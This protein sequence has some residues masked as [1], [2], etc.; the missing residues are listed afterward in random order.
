MK[1]KEVVSLLN[2]KKLQTNKIIGY[3][4]SNMTNEHSE[5][6]IWEENDRLFTIKDGIKQNVINDELK[7]LGKVP[8][9]CPQCGNIM[10][11]T[12]D[13][14]FYYQFNK[15]SDCVITEDTEQIK[16]GTFEAKQKEIIKQNKLAWFNDLKQG[17]Y[18]YI[19]ELDSTD[20]HF[21][22]EMGTL[23]NWKTNGSTD[24]LKQKMLD[25]IKKTEE[26]FLLELNKE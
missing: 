6:D 25:S 19:E 26:E 16:N 20:N 22:T 10:N 9:F 24:D 1:F 14:K 2:G 4:Y 23:E 17:V 12:M 21:V 7:K 5:G 3:S 18:E 15:C 8:M 13:K 11:K